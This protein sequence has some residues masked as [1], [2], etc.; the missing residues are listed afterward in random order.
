M[1]YGRIEY[2]SSMIVAAIVLYAGITSLVESIKKIIH[3]QEAEYSIISIVIIAV[4]VVVKFILGKY[5]KRQGEKVDSGALIASGADSIFDSILSL[6]VFISAIIYMIWSI[7]LEA[8]VGVLL[9]GFIIK[10]GFEMMMET[11][12]HIIGQR[13]D[14]EISNKI[15][16]LINDE[17]QVIGTYDL[18]LFNY[19]PDKYYATVHL[20]LPD[21]M[22]VAEVDQLTRRLQ[23]KVYKKMEIILIGVGVDSYNTKDDETSRIRNDVQKLV[24]SHDWALQLHGFY[25]DIEQKNMRFDVIVSFEKDFKDAVEI[26]T[27]E[28]QQKY[29]D[30]KILMIPDIDITDV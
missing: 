12:N 19:G 14:K 13:Q 29:P 24:L 11:I 30:Y 18:I 1:G 21:T 3:P 17:K 25:I 6:S 23:L 8:Y 4:A 9:S 15:K 5:V 22:S 28:V 2:L 20:E 10:A 27:D 16:D 26:I 7:S